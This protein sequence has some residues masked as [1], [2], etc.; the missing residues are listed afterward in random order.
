MV[1]N[2]VVKG[3]CLSSRTHWH[4]CSHFSR[5]RW[6][7]Q[8]SIT[9]ALSSDKDKG[10]GNK[11]MPTPGWEVQCHEFLG[12]KWKKSVKWPALHAN[13]TNLCNS[14]SKCSDLQGSSH[15]YFLWN[16][17]RIKLMASCRLNGSDGRKINNIFGTV[18]VTSF[19]ASVHLFHVT[20]ITYP[21]PQQ[22]YLIDAYFCQFFFKKVINL[23]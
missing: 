1:N 16:G 5:Y 14:E 20:P 4:C 7:Y 9:A 13:Q 18:S 22:H 23:I 11:V 21:L 15:L 8:F 2:G 3:L 17:S 19:P 10:M 6:I 12:W